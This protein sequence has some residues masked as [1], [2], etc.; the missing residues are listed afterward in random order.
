MPRNLIVNVVV[1]YQYA[2]RDVKLSNDELD[3]EIR[4]DLHA[5][6]QGPTYGYRMSDVNVRDVTIIPIPKKRGT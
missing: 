6:R 5:I 2:L 1:H 4:A 3:R